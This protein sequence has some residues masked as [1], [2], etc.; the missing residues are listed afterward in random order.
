M[1][2][3]WV[4]LSWQAVALIISTVALVNIFLNKPELNTFVGVAGAYTMYS[5]HAYVGIIVF[6]M[7]YLQ[8]R[9]LC[10]QVHSWISSWGRQDGMHHDV[11]QRQLEVGFIAPSD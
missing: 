4:H 5:A 2:P 3:K 10:L 6:V 11:D 9:G 8:V 7:N 1:A